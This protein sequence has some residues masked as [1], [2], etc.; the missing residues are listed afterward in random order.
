MKQTTAMCMRCKHE[1]PKSSFA[2]AYIGRRRFP[3]VCYSCYADHLTQ[4]EEAQ[5]KFLH[6]AGYLLK[7]ADELL[8]HRRYGSEGRREGYGGYSRTTMLGAVVWGVLADNNEF[9]IDLPDV[10][11]VT[12]NDGGSFRWIGGVISKLCG[13]HYA[14]I[15]WK[16]PWGGLSS[17]EQGIADGVIQELAEEFE[18]HT[19]KD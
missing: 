19:L 2:Y 12:D 18:R 4:C 6:L 7:E 16:R 8:P 17:E 9:S 11:T 13:V 14:C 15:C 3:F 10:G 1:Y 5:R